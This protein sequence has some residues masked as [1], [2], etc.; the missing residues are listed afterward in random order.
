MRVRSVQAHVPMRVTGWLTVVVVW[1]RRGLFLPL[2]WVAKLPV[3]PLRRVA[4]LRVAASIVLFLDR[5]LRAYL[6]RGMGHRPMSS[7]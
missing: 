6:C 2:D 3:G 5:P 1:G 7:L 4:L